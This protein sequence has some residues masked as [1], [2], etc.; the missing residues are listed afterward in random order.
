MFKYPESIRIAGQD[1]GPGSFMATFKKKNHP[2]VV[3]HV[4]A[5][6]DHG[7]EHV[8]VTLRSWSRMPTWDEMCFIK[9]IFWD[10]ED[11]VIQYHPA[12]KDYVDLH[13]FCLHMW[14][15]ISIEI[16]TPSNIVI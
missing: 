11:E 5:S 7:W 8:S 10:D 13:P 3:L 9:D 1:N 6:C 4:I 14:R 16:P 2:T 15:N 12:K